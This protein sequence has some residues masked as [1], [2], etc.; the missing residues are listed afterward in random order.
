ME[1]GD[2]EGVMGTAAGVEDAIATQAFMDACKVSNA[3][4]AWVA[5]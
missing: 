4:M 3:S 5:L 1:G 2:A